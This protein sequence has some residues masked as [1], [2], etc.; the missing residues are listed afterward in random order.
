MSNNNMVAVVTGGSSGIGKAT[1]LA[2][3]Q[4]GCAVYELSRRNNPPDGVLHLTADI[5]DEMQVKAAIGEIIGS[6]G[7]IDILVNNAGYGISGA[8]EMTASAAG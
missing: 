6:E 3:L 4:K 5:T 8:A 1:A 7:H 2:L